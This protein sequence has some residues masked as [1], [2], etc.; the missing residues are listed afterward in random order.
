VDD[1]HENPVVPPA[2][3]LEHPDRDDPV[4]GALDLAVIHLDDGHG[5]APAEIPGI[6]D[7][8]PGDIY[9]GDGAA[10]A[11]GHVTCQAAPAAADVEH[12]VPGTQVDL[13]ADER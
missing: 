1:F 8:L 10:V 7:L 4:E 6:A 9:G 5:Q 13:V 11:F 2:N 12:P 3:V